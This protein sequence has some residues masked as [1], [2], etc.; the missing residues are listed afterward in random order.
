MSLGCGEL[1]ASRL[2]TG[3]SP[4]SMRWHTC[5][6]IFNIMIIISD[7]DL[8]RLQDSNLSSADEL[9]VDVGIAA[10]RIHAVLAVVFTDVFCCCLRKQ[11]IHTLS[12]TGKKR[13]GILEQNSTLSKLIVHKSALTSLGS[14]FS[15]DLS[16]RT[17]EGVLPWPQ[18]RTIQAVSMA[19]RKP[20]AIPVPIGQ[21]GYKKELCKYTKMLK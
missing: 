17:F 2:K 14:H 6:H 21:N 20:R 8:I 10:R 18:L 13:R 4:V 1:T 11:P 9:C 5:T 16:A 12:E 15:S 3:P 19:A 7:Y